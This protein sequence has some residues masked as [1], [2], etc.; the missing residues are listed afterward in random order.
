MIVT[1]NDLEDH[2]ARDRGKYLTCEESASCIGRY[3]IAVQDVSQPRESA[4]SACS[5]EEWPKDRPSLSV[6]IRVGNGGC[7]CSKIVFLPVIGNV[8]TRVR[9]GSRGG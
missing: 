5:R 4:G 6:R 3:V 9:V 8:V 2:R 1:G 7:R